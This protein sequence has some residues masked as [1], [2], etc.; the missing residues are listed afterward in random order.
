MKTKQITTEPRSARSLTE[1]KYFFVLPGV[2]RDFV[3][4]GVIRYES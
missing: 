1:K 3:V 4:T 2:L